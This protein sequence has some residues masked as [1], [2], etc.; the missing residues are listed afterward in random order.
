MTAILR[1][2]LVFV[3]FLTVLVGVAILSIAAGV[4]IRYGTDVAL[5]IVGA[6]LLFV[7]VLGEMRR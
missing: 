5:I 6:I 3:R 4:S 7:A 1:D 2:K